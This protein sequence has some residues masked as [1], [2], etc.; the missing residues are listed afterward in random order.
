M[1]ENNQ[2]I[3]ERIQGIEKYVTAGIEK[4]SGDYFKARGMRQP[5]DIDKEAMWFSIHYYRNAIKTLD[6]LD[7]P[8]QAECCFHIGE[9]YLYSQLSYQR[10]R[11]YFAQAITLLDSL[12]LA[13]DQAE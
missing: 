11:N 6:N 12:G 9:C 2:E 8:L 7:I 4:S 13:K 5:Q 3:K 10:A 1:R